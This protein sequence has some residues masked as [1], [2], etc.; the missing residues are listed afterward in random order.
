MATEPHLPEAVSTLHQR[1]NREGVVPGTLY[2]RNHVAHAL[3]CCVNNITGC[4]LSGNHHTAAR[5][6]ARAAEELAR[7]RSMRW[8]RPAEE[9]AYFDLVEQYLKTVAG[10]VRSPDLAPDL[11]ER[12]PLK[13]RPEGQGD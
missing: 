11:I 4:L 7:M 10:F 12:I 3:V 8:E 13:W 6:V 5:F 1:L 2:R 9:L